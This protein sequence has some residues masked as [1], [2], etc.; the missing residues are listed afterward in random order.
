MDLLEYQ[1]KQL[2][3]SLEKGRPSP[4]T[5]SPQNRDTGGQ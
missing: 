5:P 4:S 3:Q 2:Q 1:G